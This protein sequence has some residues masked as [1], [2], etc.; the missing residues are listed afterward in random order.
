M[1]LCISPDLDGYRVPKMQHFNIHVRAS[2]ADSRFRPFLAIF[3]LTFALFAIRIKVAE[4]FDIP[5]IVS[6]QVT[7]RFGGSS[8]SASSAAVADESFLTAALG[9]V[10]SHCVNTRLVLER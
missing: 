3:A 2:E 9:T 1:C 7:T 6:N 10:W 4:T 8:A 5:V